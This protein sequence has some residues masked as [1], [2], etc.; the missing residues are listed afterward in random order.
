MDWIADDEF[1]ARWL[2][3]PQAI[4]VVRGRSYLR[5]VAALSVRFAPSKV[6]TP[7][8]FRDTHFVMTAPMT[9]PMSGT[10][11]RRTILRP[12]IWAGALA[13]MMSAPIYLPL[14]ASAL[15]QGAHKHP[16][17]AQGKKPATPQ[18]AA[19]AAAQAPKLPARIPFTAADDAAATIPGMPDARFFADSIADFNKAL[20][21]QPGPWLVLSTGGSDGAFGSG[22]LNGLSAAGNRPD[23]SVVTGVSS[24]A[25]MAPFVFAGSRYDASAHRRLYKDLG[26]RHLRS[27]RHR[28]E[29]SRHLAA[30]GSDR[31]T[32]HA[33]SFSPISLPRTKPAGGSLSSP[34]ISM[35]SARWSG[36][37]A[38]SPCTRKRTAATRP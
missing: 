24:G 15:A 12:A 25:L 22:L 35:P 30:Q 9:A 3:L 34:P 31:Q 11:L 17:H 28:R 29:L 5:P 23:Y 7:S 27:R 33:R 13:V 10:V 20:P 16:S 6:R 19:P 4:D 14:G 37:W 21:S 8:P 36:T 2:F 32:N 18:T 26:G 1:W 38:R